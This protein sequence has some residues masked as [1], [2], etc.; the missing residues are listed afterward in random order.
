MKRRELPWYDSQWSDEMDCHER[1]E[2]NFWCQQRSNVSP[3]PT[4]S[5]KA[6]DYGQAKAASYLFTGEQAGLWVAAA[7]EQTLI[8]AQ[9]Y[10][11]GDKSVV[12]FLC[13]RSAV[14]GGSLNKGLC[15]L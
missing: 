15:L 10:Q 9:R 1:G 12:L 7:H 13:I 2:R 5:H 6:T 11:T 14:S 3:S 8:S 4:S